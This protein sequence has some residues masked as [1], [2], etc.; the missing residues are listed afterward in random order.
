M[1]LWLRGDGRSDGAF[2]NT[3]TPDD[4]AF[5]LQNS[6]CVLERNFS[7]W[8]RRNETAV[9]IIMEQEEVI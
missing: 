9:W 4:M 7:L 1:L 5:V 6:V 3:V 2:R 8:R